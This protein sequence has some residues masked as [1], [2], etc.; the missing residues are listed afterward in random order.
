MNLKSAA[1]FEINKNDRL[2]QFI[3]PVGAPLGEC[4]DALHAILVEVTEQAK[5]ATD[6][7]KKED[8][9]EASV[10]EAEVVEKQ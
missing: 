2:F 3:A 9:Q 4:Y 10:V 5:K 6:A 8:K 1:I 7:V